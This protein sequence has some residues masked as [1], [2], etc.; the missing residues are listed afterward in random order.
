VLAPE[1]LSVEIWPP[2]PTSGMRVGMPKCVKIIHRP[3]GLF[4]TC[5]SER[6]QHLCRDKALADLEVKVAS[7]AAQ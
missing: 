4:A 2:L 7:H 6:S 3:S 5:D 1:D